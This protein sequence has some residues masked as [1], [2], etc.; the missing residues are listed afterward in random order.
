[1]SEPGSDIGRLVAARDRVV[2][3]VR[4]VAFGHALLEKLDAPFKAITAHAWP[5]RL[6]PD[7]PAGALDAALAASL[8]PGALDTRAL[9]PLPV[10]GLP[11]WC[12]AN[13]DPAF[14][15]DAAV[16]RPGRRG[17]A[18]GAAVSVRS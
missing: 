18:G 10:M 3:S 11:G 9:C 13:E 4:V 15:N 17:P 14:Y 8:E 2:V 1:M 12:G 7:T 5:L 16:F 6:P